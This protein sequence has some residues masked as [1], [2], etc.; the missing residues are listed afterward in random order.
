[1]TKHRPVP[2]SLDDPLYY[3]ENMDILVAW[4]ADHHADLL[5]QQERNRLAAYKGLAT[6]SRALLTRMVMSTGELFRAEKLLY[7]ELPVPEDEALKLLVHEGWLDNSPELRL[8]HLFRLFTL[9]ELRPVFG[10]WLHEQCYPKTVGKAQMRECLSEPFSA[11]RP[12]R[13]WMGD[14][15]DA[16]DVL[17]LHDMALCDR[18]R[19]MFSGNLR[20]SWTD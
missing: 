16:A 12:L 2:A 20:Q 10:G 5:T 4:V 9:A 8:D 18:I 17:Q 15:G 6:G 19:L 1:M 14:D 13:D 11:P 3:L 7:P